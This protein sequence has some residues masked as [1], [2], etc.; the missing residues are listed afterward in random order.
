MFKKFGLIVRA[1]FSIPIRIFYKFFPSAA[2]QA[3]IDQ[4]KD[5]IANA[6]KTMGEIVG[7]E[8]DLKLQVKN[9]EKEVR[10]LERRVNIAL[11]ADD[12]AKAV[13]LSGKLATAQSSLKINKSQLK[14]QSSSVES[15]MSLL[16]R[17]QE[18][19][20][21]LEDRATTMGVQLKNAKAMSK[22]TDLAADLQDNL[23]G[24]GL[25]GDAMDNMQRAIH[26]E[27]GNAEVSMELMDDDLDSRE[28]MEDLDAQDAL[29][30]IKAKRAKDKEASK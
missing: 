4:K 25:L 17:N 10:Q 15:T 18:D 23:Q 29:A 7:L 13:K 28:E 3:A 26:A 24:N 12:D 22:Q 8:K 11:D 30:A 1:F 16:K 21:K 14:R 20:S 5:D 27:E 2:V 19:L 6:R 9:G